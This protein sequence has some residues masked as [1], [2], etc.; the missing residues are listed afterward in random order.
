MNHTYM[1]K[2]RLVKSAN[3]LWRGRFIMLAQGKGNLR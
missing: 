3:K 1:K 2:H